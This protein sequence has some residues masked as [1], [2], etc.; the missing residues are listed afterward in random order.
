MHAANERILNPLKPLDREDN[1]FP[2]PHIKI[3]INPDT[4]KENMYVYVGHDEGVGEFIMRDWFVMY[5]EDL[6]T[7]HSTTRVP[8]TWLLCLTASGASGRVL[9]ILSS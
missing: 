3:F 1:R 6:V 5:S 7:W 9:S 4:G 8:A 2:D